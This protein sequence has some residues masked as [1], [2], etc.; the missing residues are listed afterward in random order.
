MTLRTRAIKV[1]SNNAE[2]NKIP[3][4]LP[5]VMVPGKRKYK[6]KCLCPTQGNSMLSYVD[7]YYTARDWVQP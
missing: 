2:G 1:Y 3:E 6:K 5:N 7:Y 4:V